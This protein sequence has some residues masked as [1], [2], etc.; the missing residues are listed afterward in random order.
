MAN[1]CSPPIAIRYRLASKPGPVF[2]PSLARLL[3][4][5]CHLPSHPRR[6]S[7]TTARLAQFDDGH[8]RAI[9]VQGDEGAAQ[10]VRLGHRGTPSVNMQRRSCHVPAARPI[11]SSCSA[12]DKQRFRGFGRVEADRPSAWRYHPSSRQPRPSNEGAHADG[13][14]DV[15]PQNQSFGETRDSGLG[16]TSKPRNRQR[17]RRFESISLQRSVCELSVSCSVSNAALL[18]Y[19]RDP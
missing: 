5:H 3:P 15:C 18:A 17:N 8:D 7:A 6:R 10:V 12:R 11:A 19:L 2:S 16:Q 13:G 1:T 14:G 9:L 4:R